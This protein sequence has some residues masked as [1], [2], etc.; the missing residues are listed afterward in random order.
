MCH[1]ALSARLDGSLM[2][3][4]RASAWEVFHVFC[5]MEMSRLVEIPCLT[6]TMSHGN[7]HAEK[8]ISMKEFSKL[9]VKYGVVLRVD[10]RVNMKL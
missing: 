9:Y 7:P 6:I 1:K 4:N 5:L 3:L 8:S 2:A 10:T